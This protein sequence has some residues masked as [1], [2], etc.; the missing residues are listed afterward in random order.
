MIALS[1]Y[2]TQPQVAIIVLNWNNVHDTLDC[3]RCL[4]HLDYSH[5]KILV[6]DNGSNDDSVLTIHANFPE[7][8]ILETGE[9]LG[10]A[11]G[12]NVGIHHALKDGAEFICILNNDVI[13]EPA[14]LTPLL[15]ALEAD[16]RAGIATSL[17]VDIRDKTRVWSL[18]AC[19]DWKTGS[20]QRLEA[21]K[22]VAELTNLKPFEVSIAPGSAMLVKRAVFEKAGFLDERY[23][24]YYE[25]ADWCIGVRKAGFKILAVPEACVIHHVSATLGQASPVTDYYMARNRI[26]FIRRHW[27]GQQRFR[28]LGGIYL[29]QVATIIAYTVKSHGDQKLLNRNTRLYAL[30]DGLLGRW[31]KMGDDVARVCLPR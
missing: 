5:Y 2:V 27:R 15:N 11:G 12:N 25:E 22:P 13:V 29:R 18:G 26:H 30:R 19:V 28:L 8:P 23:F 20:V 17:I 1:K 21:N 3:L 9:N 24:L 16:P 7:I 4:A 10:Y 14:F 6:V 31:G